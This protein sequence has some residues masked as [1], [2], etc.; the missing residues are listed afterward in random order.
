[1]GRLQPV[2]TLL[3]DQHVNWLYRIDS[4]AASQRQ[5]LSHSELVRI[6]IDRLRRD[7]DARSVAAMV[8]ETSPSTRGVY[9][10]YALSEDHITWL[11]E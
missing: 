4:Q 3:T 6:A 9:G 2:G 1:M 11:R 8:N 10:T 5:R 7:R